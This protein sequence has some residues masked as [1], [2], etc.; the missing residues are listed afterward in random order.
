MRLLGNVIPTGNEFCQLYLS[1]SLH[2]ISIVAPYP[3]LRE[4]KVDLYQNTPKFS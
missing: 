1:F 4:K 2:T 3:T